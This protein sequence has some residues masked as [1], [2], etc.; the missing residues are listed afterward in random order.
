MSAFVQGQD[1]LTTSVTLNGVT[2]GNLLFL[3]SRQ[4]SNS[5]QLLSV[6]DGTANSWVVAEAGNNP[7]LALGLGSAYVLSTVGGN[8]TITASYDSPPTSQH[9][10]LAEYNCKALA[11]DISD[12]IDNPTGTPSLSI[13]PHTPAQDSELHLTYAL[14]QILNRTLNQPST[15]SFTMDVGVLDFSSADVNLALASYT[16]T[17]NPGAE[18]LTWQSDGGTTNQNFVIGWVSFKI[19]TGIDLD[20][21]PNPRLLVNGL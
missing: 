17:V 18:S 16:Q 1:S 20:G 3:V 13:G 6:S 12:T 19:K 4:E 9:L 8:I 10:I 7:D 21:S 11:V 5:R 2:A 14:G 15:P